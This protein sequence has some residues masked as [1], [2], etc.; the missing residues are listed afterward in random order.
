MVARGRT[1]VLDFGE[2]QAIP[3]QRLR[4]GMRAWL[5]GPVREAAVVYVNGKRAGSVWTPPYSV[6]I[7]GLLTPGAN[8]LKILVANLAL[9][10]M[11]GRPLPDY[12]LLNLRYG[13][14]FDAQDMNLVQ[15]I[16]AGL[17]GPIQI[18]VR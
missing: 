5:D 6:D 18:I 13:S 17:M 14:R 7:T 16:A 3:P 12:K 8:T 11:A 1:V 4:N 2:G 15:P 9:N 10:D